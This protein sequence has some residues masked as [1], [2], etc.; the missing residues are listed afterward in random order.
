MIASSAAQSSPSCAVQD[1][2]DGQ[3]HPCQPQTNAKLEPIDVDHNL[4]L[5]VQRLTTGATVHR[6]SQ[7]LTIYLGN[8]ELWNQFVARG[9][10]DPAEV[11]E[12]I[13]L[14]DRALATHLQLRREVFAEELR[15]TG[16]SRSQC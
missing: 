9:F 15:S 1:H 7:A 8:A 11:Q 5:R 3:S 12:K 10:I 4:V 13:V 16:M 6:F 14:R 2:F